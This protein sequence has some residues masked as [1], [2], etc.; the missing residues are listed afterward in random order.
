MD[1]FLV[2]GAVRDGLLDL[3]V[4]ERDWVVVG[5]TPVA[6]TAMGYRPIDVDFPVF[7]HPETG[8]EY[9]LARREIKQGPGYRGFSIDAGPNVSLVDDLRRRDLTINAMAR[10]ADGT[11]VDPFG[12]RDDLDAGLLRHVSA[13]F[14]EDP[15]R[16]LRIARFA[17]KLGRFGFRV[18]HG[19]HRLLIE[20]VDAGAMQELTAERLWR[21]TRRAL[22]TDRPWRYFEVLQ[23]CGALQQ[24]LPALSN[25]LGEQAAHAPAQ[26]SA[27]IA[28]L[29]RVAIQTTQPTQRLLAMLWSVVVDT[30]TAEQLITG[31]RVDRLTARLL[32]RIAAAHAIWERTVEGDYDAMAALALDWLA[33]NASPRQ[34]LVEA[35]AAQAVEPAI[36]ARITAA[37]E[38]AERVDTA[39]L[40]EQGLRGAELGSAIS[41]AR[42]AAV[43]SA[44]RPS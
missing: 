11:L 19:T 8:E 16:V 18:A 14:S 20:M 43:E 9:A 2:G 12:G 38:A 3:P 28:A 6:M 37:M 42:R 4:T 30:E 36:I 21:E 35:A 31:L 25:A 34:A 5:A 29:K 27:P 26:D 7:R 1:A 22:E 33:V 32:R 40:R 24:L 39:L 13:A 44:V 10:A 41:S 23:R 15:L 17:A